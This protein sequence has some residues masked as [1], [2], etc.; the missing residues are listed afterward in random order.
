MGGA[1]DKS[2]GR[3]Q[4]KPCVCLGH[5]NPAAGF[6]ACDCGELTQGAKIVA[7]AVWP[8]NAVSAA[9]DFRPSLLERMFF[10][11]VGIWN[12][13]VGA[14]SMLGFT[15]TA[16]KW[17][18]IFVFGILAM[19]T[20]SRK[21]FVK[22]YDNADDHWGIIFTGGLFL[23]PAVVTLIAAIAFAFGVEIA[24]NGGDRAQKWDCFAHLFSNYVQPFLIPLAITNGLSLLYEIGRTKR[25]FQNTTA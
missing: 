24:I 18:A 16:L 7:L 13:L 11:V 15:F 12:V 6:C 20:T 8:A 23:Y 9:P 2:F 1:M 5:S 4:G 25:K 3:A 19:P 22:E 17:V 14:L 10:P 21:V